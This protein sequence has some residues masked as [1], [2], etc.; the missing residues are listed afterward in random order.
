MRFTACL[1]FPRQAFFVRL[2]GARTIVPGLKEGTKITLSHFCC[3]SEGC[4]RIIKYG[5]PR[6]L[7]ELLG[8]YHDPKILNGLSVTFLIFPELL[9]I[10][11]IFCILR[12]GLL[13]HLQQI[14]IQ[15]STFVK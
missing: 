6:I 3:M 4:I 14:S 10:R 5:V 13:Y 2:A 8:Y 11:I 12:G 15:K 9:P 7:V 1:G